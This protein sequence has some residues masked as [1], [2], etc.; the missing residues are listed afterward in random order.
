MPDHES[1]LSELEQFLWDW[2]RES[3]RLVVTGS[4][5]WTDR[6]T[7]AQAIKMVNEFYPISQAI[8]GAARGADIMFGEECSKI[9]VRDITSVPA[10]WGE[11]D[12][13][14]PEWH[15]GMSKCKRAGYRR[16][17]EMAEMKPD[18]CLAF[19]VGD[20]PGTGMMINICRTHHIPVVVFTVDK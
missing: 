5:S 9:G 3:I 12:E 1:S 10:R 19:R 11:H 17:V 15:T 7:I 13:G 8:H 20:S 6:R 4:R 16:N 2:E 14:C 18:L